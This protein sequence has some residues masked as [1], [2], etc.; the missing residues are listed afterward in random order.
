MM[1]GAE[2]LGSVGVMCRAIFGVVR[3]TDVRSNVMHL[4]APTLK[5]RMGEGNA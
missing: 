5:R 4:D 3:C 1:T 2:K